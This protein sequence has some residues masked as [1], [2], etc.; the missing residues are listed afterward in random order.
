MRWE[1]ERDTPDKYNDVSLKSE[2]RGLERGGGGGWTTKGLMAGLFG[3]DG[4]RR[5]LYIYIYISPSSC[6][7]NIKDVEQNTEQ[8]GAD[9]WRP[10][11]RRQCNQEMGSVVFSL[12]IFRSSPLFSFFFFFTCIKPNYLDRIIYIYMYKC[13]ISLT[14]SLTDD[15][16][17]KR[18]GNLNRPAVGKWTLDPST[19]FSFSAPCPSFLIYTFT[20]YDNQSAWGRLYRPAIRSPPPVIDVVLVDDARKPFNLNRDIEWPPVFFFFFW[21]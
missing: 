21:F 1:R 7:S 4:E 20:S 11:M 16:V 3:N 12:S 14:L 5:V 17:K 19:S 6:A 9:A 15:D 10:V 13:W 18:V 2:K 8:K